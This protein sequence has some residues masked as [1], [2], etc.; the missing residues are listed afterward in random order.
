MLSGSVAF[1]FIVD[2][3]QMQLHFTAILFSP[4]TNMTKDTSSRKRKNN[5]TNTS[6]QSE[7][8]DRE[9][10]GSEDSEEEEQPASRAATPSMASKTHSLTEVLDKIK[11]NASSRSKQGSN[12]SHNAT[13]PP[14]DNPS[15]ANEIPMRNTSRH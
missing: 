4:N 5:S 8:K 10:E 6:R 2:C 1:Y 12:N 13:I 15:T 11:K 3:S 14:T 9:A 7:D